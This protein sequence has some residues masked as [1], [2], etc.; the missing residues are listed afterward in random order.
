MWKPTVQV[1]RSY[2]QV[3]DVNYLRKSTL[4]PGDAHAIDNRSAPAVDERL[5]YIARNESISDTRAPSGVG[6]SDVVNH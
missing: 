5:A 1:R 3:Y 4:P 2:R 6:G